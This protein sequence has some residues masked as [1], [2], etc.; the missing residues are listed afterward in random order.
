[1]RVFLQPVARYL[2]KKPRNGLR[3]TRFEEKVPNLENGYC[4]GIEVL[5]H[6]LHMTRR[7]DLVSHHT[8]AA[9]MRAMEDAGE[10]AGRRKEVKIELHYDNFYTGE[11]GPGLMARVRVSWRA[12][13]AGQW[14]TGKAETVYEAIREIEERAAL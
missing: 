6:L 2:P 7:R 12:R 8:R 9:I 13:I 11:Q 5:R 4:A 1:L 10:W 3:E 14:Q